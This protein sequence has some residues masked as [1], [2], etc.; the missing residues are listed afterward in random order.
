MAKDL[1]EESGHKT[2]WLAL[3]NLVYGVDESRPNGNESMANQSQTI[4]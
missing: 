1:P 2:F 4:R 3:F